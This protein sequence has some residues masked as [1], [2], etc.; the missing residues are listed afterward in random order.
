MARRNSASVSN[1]NSNGKGGIGGKGGSTCQAGG[2]RGRE[3]AGSGRATPAG[4]GDSD[5]ED[6]EV[7]EDREEPR[8]AGRGGRGNGGGRICGQGRGAKRH[9]SVPPLAEHQEQKQPASPHGRCGLT[10]QASLSAHVPGSL[11]GHGS[12]RLASPSPH[13]VASPSG[14][15]G[16]TSRNNSDVSARM[17]DAK[18][19]AAAAAHASGVGVRAPH[20]P[21]AAVPCG[22]SASELLGGRQLRHPGLVLVQLLPAQDAPGGGGGGGAGA[23]GAEAP[24][25][26]GG[27]PV[28][29][30]APRLD[31]P[32]VLC[33]AKWTVAHV[34]QV[35]GLRAGGLRNRV[36]S[37]WGT[38]SSCCWAANTLV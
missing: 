5:M 25:N 10:H 22:R 3:G 7:E 8:G 23:V 2:K 35:G 32:F 29:C 30:V 34:A 9:H 19:A 24:C 18:A 28:R 4:D 21:L 12:S 37:V 38:P 33:P 27:R 13:P 11:P 6:V 15:G 1:V 31:K 20:G 16:S 14:R 17:V 36:K 26:P